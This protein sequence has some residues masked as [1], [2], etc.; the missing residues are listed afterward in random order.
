MRCFVL[1][2]KFL[3]PNAFYASESQ[4]HVS[5]VCL[6]CCDVVLSVFNFRSACSVCTCTCMSLFLTCLALRA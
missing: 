1:C 4:T 5:D 6:V 2:V 3:E